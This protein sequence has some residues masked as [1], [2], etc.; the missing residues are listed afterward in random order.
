MWIRSICIKN[1]ISHIKHFCNW[2]FNYSSSTFLSQLTFLYTS[3]LTNQIFCWFIFL[4][5]VCALAPLYCSRVRSQI[6][7]FPVL[8]AL[9]GNWVVL[10]C[11][12]VFMHLSSSISFVQYYFNHLY[13][14]AYHIKPL[15]HILH[16]SVS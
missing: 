2:Y 9:I 13:I 6:N 8:S 5:P 12:Y 16:P 7:V 4:N 1:I 11:I 14:P 10:L 3:L 15:L